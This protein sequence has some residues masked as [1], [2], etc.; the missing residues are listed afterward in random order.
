MGNIYLV[1]IFLIVIFI[2]GISIMMENNTFIKTNCIKEIN[3]RNKVCE[4]N[5]DAKE[6]KDL[7]KKYINCLKE[8]G[9]L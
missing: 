8:N 3:M 7:H 4:Y 9:K 1:I 2:S 5:S 6:C